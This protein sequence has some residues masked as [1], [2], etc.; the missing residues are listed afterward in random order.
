MPIPSRFALY[1]ALL[2]LSALQAFATPAAVQRCQDASGHFTFTTMGCPEDQASETREFFN[3]PPGS[4]MPGLSAPVTNG[5]S[6]MAM[7]DDV[8]IVGQRDDGCGNQLSGEARRRAI[9]NKRVVPGMSVREVENLLGRPAKVQHRNGELRYQ[10]EDRKKKI[11]HLV[12]FD[13]QGCV[14]GKP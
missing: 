6:P 2:C 9:I 11:S 10:Y 12:T 13:S 4:V 7:N 14:R 1:G 3:A 5:P 8:V